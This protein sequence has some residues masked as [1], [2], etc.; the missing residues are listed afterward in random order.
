MP[1]V[2]MWLLLL[3]RWLRLGRRAGGRFRAMAFQRRSGRYA[4][5]PRCHDRK[6]NRRQHEQNRRDRRRLRQQRGRTARTESRLRPHPAKSP[7]QIRRL[8]ALQQNDDDQ[9]KTHH[10]VNEYEKS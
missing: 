10:Y 7:G 2:L 6:R 5:A 3:R 1:G 4:R 8:T 9:E